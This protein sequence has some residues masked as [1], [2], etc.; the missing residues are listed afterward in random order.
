MRDTVRSSPIVMLAWKARSRRK[1]AQPGD[2]IA[3]EPP[4]LLRVAR[5]RPREVHAEPE[6]RDVEIG[7]LVD[8][9]EVDRAGP[10]ARD[11]L[12]GAFEIEGQAERAGEVVGRAERQDAERQARLDDARRRGID[13]AVAPADHD[14]PDLTG[15]FPD[16]LRHPFAR[17]RMAADDIETGSPE[18]GFRL[19]AALPS[20]ATMLVDDQEGPRRVFGGLW[21]NLG[22]SGSGM[23]RTAS[24]RA[25]VLGRDN[26]RRSGCGP[27][28]RDHNA[29]SAARSSLGRCLIGTTALPSKRRSSGC[30][31][32]EAVVTEDPS[33]AEEPG[34]VERGPDPRRE[35]ERHRIDPVEEG[36]LLG[37][38]DPVFRADAAVEAGRPRR[39]SGARPARTAVVAGPSAS[40]RAG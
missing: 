35:V 4:T 25:R 26:P 2:R 36:P 11:D 21:R 22:G 34:R 32:L 14:A 17:C 33:R 8:L 5:Q 23:T 12:R 30:S 10:A 24:M 7:M 39:R 3:E 9:A 1:H 18:Q 15:Q 20:G 37:A 27:V 29:G 13:G 6:A 31:A 28:R 19:V 40:P 38:A 16:P